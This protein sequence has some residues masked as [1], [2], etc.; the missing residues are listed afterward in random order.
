MLRRLHSCITE[1]WCLGTAVAMMWLKLWVA[2]EK[3]CDFFSSQ[4]PEMIKA[5]TKQNHS[6]WNFS[7]QNRMRWGSTVTTR[8]ACVIWLRVKTF[9]NSFFN[10]LSSKLAYFINAKFSLFGFRHQ[11]QLFWY[12][13]LQNVWPWE[14]AARKEEHFRSWQLIVGGLLALLYWSNRTPQRLLTEA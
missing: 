4:Y 8:R 9:S 13:F 2:F 11:G 5:L 3:E 1:P 12:A 6:A 7:W 14:I 10:F